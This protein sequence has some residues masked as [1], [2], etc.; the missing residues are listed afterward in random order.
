[1]GSRVLFAGKTAKLFYIW[2]AQRRQLREWW[3][4]HENV[5]AFGV[6]ELLELL[7]DLY[8]VIHCLADPRYFGWASERPRQ[9]CTLVLKVWACSVLM[10]PRK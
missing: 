8:V 9:I 1:M 3:I 7:G 4:T 10:D 2:V 5:P 6:T